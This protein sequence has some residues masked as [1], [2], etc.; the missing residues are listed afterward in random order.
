MVRLAMIDAL[1]PQEEEGIVEE[2][3]GW[4]GVQF[5]RFNSSNARGLF[6]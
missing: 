4:G 5:C 2:W 3:R 1:V 6:C